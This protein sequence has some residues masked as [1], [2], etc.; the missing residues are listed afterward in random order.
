MGGAKIVG[1]SGEIPGYNSCVYTMTGRNG[2][3][4]IVFLNRYPSKIEG[5]SDQFLI[6]LVKAVDS[7]SK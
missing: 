3:T 6:E 1:H 2:A 4:F 5:A 7:A